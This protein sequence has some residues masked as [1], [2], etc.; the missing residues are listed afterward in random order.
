MASK[1]QF[2]RQAKRLTDTTKC[3]DTCVDILSVCVDIRSVCDITVLFCV[4]LRTKFIDNDTFE[5]LCVAPHSVCCTSFEFV[6][7][8]NSLMWLARCLSTHADPEPTD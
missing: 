1:C 3:V 2:S 4:S 6:V 8:S 5:S 7:S